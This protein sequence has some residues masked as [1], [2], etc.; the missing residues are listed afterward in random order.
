MSQTNRTTSEWTST[1]AY[2]L[3]V[4]CLLVGSV[5]GYLLRGSASQAPAPVASEQAAPAGMGGMGSGQMPTPEQLKRMADKQAEPV[6]AQLKSDP[7]NPELLANAGNMYYD[8]QQY[9]TAIEFYSKSLQADPKNTNVRTDL[10]TSYWYLGDADKAIATFDEVLKQEPNKA[11]AL[12][13]RGIVK[14]QGKMDVDGAVKDWQ[15]LLKTNPNYEARDKVEQFIAQAQKHSN[16]KP[17][18]KTE[19]PAM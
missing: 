18:Q 8:A 3:A 12:F 14:W 5:V 16:I 6:L 19:K 2:V 17:G 7:N 4:I 13:N 10:A 9:P 11:N 15:T 1:Q